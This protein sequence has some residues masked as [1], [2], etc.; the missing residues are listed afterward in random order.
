MYFVVIVLQAIGPI[1][2]KTQAFIQLV[3]RHWR[4]QSVDEGS[5]F[6]FTSS[7]EDFLH[8]GFVQAI[9]VKFTVL[10]FIITLDKIPKVVV[11]LIKLKCWAT[12]VLKYFRL[13]L[14]HCSFC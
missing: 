3:V 9:L 7:A 12:E 6:P 4:L 8:T 2:S 11:I 10:L 14:L 1:Y 13:I 5:V